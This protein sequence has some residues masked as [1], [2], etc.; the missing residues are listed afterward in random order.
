M[1]PLTSVEEVGFANIDAYE[2]HKLELG[3]PLPDKE[4]EI[5]WKEVI[6]KCKHM[7]SR[8][9]LFREGGCKKSGLLLSRSR[10][11]EKNQTSFLG[12]KKS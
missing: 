10:M 12:S 2:S 11:E 5:R 1:L 6:L 8:G 9:I 3:K 4:Q 7:G